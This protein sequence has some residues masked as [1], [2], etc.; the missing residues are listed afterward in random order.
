MATRAERLGL[1]PRVQ[2][3]FEDLNRPSANKLFLAA[4][5]RGIPLTLSQA[6]QFIATDDV[7]QEFAPA[8]KFRG[9]I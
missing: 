1:D 8:P 5:E 4:V 9:K 2:Q 7:R 6:R 3:L